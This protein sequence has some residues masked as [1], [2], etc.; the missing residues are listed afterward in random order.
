MCCDGLALY[1]MANRLAHPRSYWFIVL[2]ICTHVIWTVVLP[3][4]GH[5]YI[6]ELMSKG[7]VDDL[8][9]VLHVKNHTQEAY[10]LK[11]TICKLNLSHIIITFKVFSTQSH[12]SLDW[13]LQ[14]CRM[15]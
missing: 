3:I 13:R 7:I 2:F 11:V 5:F 15:Q 8:K 9:E 10:A 14:P 12:A 1:S 4:L 6:E